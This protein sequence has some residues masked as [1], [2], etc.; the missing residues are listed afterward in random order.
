ML[1]NSRNI[2]DWYKYKIG[3]DAYLECNLFIVLL[4]E[5]LSEKNLFTNV[6]ISLI[7]DFFFKILYRVGLVPELFSISYPNSNYL[8]DVCPL[9]VHIFNFHKFINPIYDVLP[10]KISHP[11]N[12]DCLMS[13]VFGPLHPFWCKNIYIK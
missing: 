1:N 4:Y 11:V 3:G 9:F 5:Y 8:E 10:S 7:Y 12:I 6:F 2:E 13:L